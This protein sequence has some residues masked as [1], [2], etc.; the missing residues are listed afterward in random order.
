MTANNQDSVLRPDPASFFKCIQRLRIEI[1]AIQK[2][3]CD[4][5][6]F[7]KMADHL[8][9][10]LHVKEDASNTIIS[11]VEENERLLTHLLDGMDDAAK[12]DMIVKISASTWAYL[13]AISSRTSR[14]SG[15]PGLSSFS[16]MSKAG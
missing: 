7:E 13:N 5:Y 8:D 11:T 15:L 10:I 6:H 9:T 12:L 14:T 2:R 3:A 1:A 4:D 16:P